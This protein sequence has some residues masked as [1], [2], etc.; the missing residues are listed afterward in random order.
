[1]IFLLFLFFCVFLFFKKGKG[2]NCL[3][4]QEFDDQKTRIFG[5]YYLTLT[6][7]LL[8]QF[9]IFKKKYPL[10]VF[11]GSHYFWA[12]DFYFQ[13]LILCVKFCGWFPSIFIIYLFI[14]YYYY[15]SKIF[16]IKNSVQVVE[17]WCTSFHT[18]IWF[19]S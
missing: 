18:K 19:V 10:V 13:R 7:K 14:Y 11:S 9:K 12:F 15:F 17:F 8:N 16:N 6:Q 1:M 4:T 5:H 2:I 3:L